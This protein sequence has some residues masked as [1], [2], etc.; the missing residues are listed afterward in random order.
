MKKIFS[1]LFAKHNENKNEQPTQQVENNNVQQ[2]NNQTNQFPHLVFALYLNRH[3]SLTIIYDI[4]QIKRKDGEVKCISKITKESKQLLQINNIQID[5]LKD[6][7]IFPMKQLN[8]FHC[9]YC[10]E[11]PKLTTK[12]LLEVGVAQLPHG[13]FK[14][15]LDEQTTDHQQMMQWYKRQVDYKMYRYNAS[16][17]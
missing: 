6:V 14:V 1:K 10:S 4:F 16:F 17:F 8:T 12:Q 13:C 2:T 7:I 15:M 9:L 5:F 3:F 11:K